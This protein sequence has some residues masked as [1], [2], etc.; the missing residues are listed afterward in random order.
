MKVQSELPSGFASMFWIFTPSCRTSNE[1]AVWA[2]PACDVH[3]SPTYREG[4]EVSFSC[5]SVTGFTDG[6]PK[7]VL[8]LSAE[9]AAEL[10]P[11]ASTAFT[12]R[13][14]SAFVSRCT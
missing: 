8:S 1:V 7:Y 11:A 6:G 13:A 4:C 9:L 10:C 3:V 5:K 12:V 2:V 14:Y